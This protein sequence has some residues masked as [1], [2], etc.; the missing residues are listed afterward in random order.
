MLIE[1]L[2]RKLEASIKEYT[3]DMDRKAKVEF[4]NTTVK[5]ALDG[6]RN[7]KLCNDPTKLKALLDRI[8]VESRTVAA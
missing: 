4:V 7:Y 1:D 2:R 6:E 8:E 3:K 5:T